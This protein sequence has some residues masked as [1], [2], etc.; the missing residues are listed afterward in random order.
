[1]SQ[2]PS[3]HD[4]DALPGS[5]AAERRWLEHTRSQIEAGTPPFDL[6]RNWQRL[7]AR[8]EAEGDWQRTAQAR[9]PRPRF[10]W[11]QALVA[12]GLGAATAA[13]VAVSVWPLMPQLGGEVEP[14]G[15]PATPVAADRVMLQ[16]VFRADATVAQIRAALDQA[17]AEVVGGPGRLGVWRVAVPASRVAAARRS[18]AT[19]AIVE[20]VGE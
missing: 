13:I 19:Q 3:D 20:S 4:Q 5:D 17:D 10:P 8:V 6:A 9:P 15:A 2:T 1:M 18:L 12:Y 11:W 7:A 14:L 16:V